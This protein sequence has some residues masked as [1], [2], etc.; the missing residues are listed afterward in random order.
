MLLSLFKYNG[1]VI[2]FYLEGDYDNSKYVDNLC[3]IV[4]WITVEDMKK[5]NN[6]YNIRELLWKLQRNKIKIIKE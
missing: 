1:D 3:I 5:G 6:K 4:V 2:F